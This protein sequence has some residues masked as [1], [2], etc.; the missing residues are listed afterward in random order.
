V[1]TKLKTIALGLALI[2]TVYGG[3]QAMDARYEVKQVH[4][5][6]HAIIVAGMDNF[7]YTILKREIR[8]IRELI[9]TEGNEARLVQLQ[10][11]LQDAIDRLCKQFPE[12]REC[13]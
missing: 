6:E 9:Y 5:P 3:T 4:E 7:S 8:E 10:L 13:K 12:D 2:A 1:D 11:E